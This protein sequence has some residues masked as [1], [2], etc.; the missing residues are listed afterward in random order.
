MIPQQVNYFSGFL[1]WTARAS[2]IVL[3]GLFLSF[4]LGDEPLPKLMQEPLSVQL[5]FAGWAIIFLGYVVGWRFRVA[6]GV[7]V[8]SALACMYLVEYSFHGRWLGPAF[9]LWSLPGFLFLLIALSN[10]LQS[11]A[12]GS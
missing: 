12:K 6:G 9:L 3:L 10:K 2:S 1:S 8:L 11:T 5:L 4:L 7:L